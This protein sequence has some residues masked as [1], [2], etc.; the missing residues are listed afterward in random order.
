LKPFDIIWFVVVG[1]LALYIIKADQKSN[2]VAD[3]MQGQID[4]LQGEN[5][6]LLVLQEEANLRAL[7]WERAAV[8]AMDSVNL[9]NETKQSI[10][11]I[12]E[13]IDRDIDSYTFDQ[14]DSSLWSRYRHLKPQGSRVDNDRDP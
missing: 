5:D 11:V 7:L 3:R 1:L 4:R 6:S 14:R 2:I 12:Y 8:K 10:R 13:Q 9:L